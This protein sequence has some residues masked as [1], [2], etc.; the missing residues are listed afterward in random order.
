M[1]D[2]L[3]ADADRRIAD[4]VVQV[5]RYRESTSDARH[6]GGVEPTDSLH[7]AMTSGPSGNGNQSESVGDDGVVREL[8]VYEKND[9]LRIRG[10]KYAW[11]FTTVSSLNLDYRCEDGKKVGEL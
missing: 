9:V 1:L 2:S 4:H 5:H 3:D 8:Q 7:T 10:T 6:G 11:Q